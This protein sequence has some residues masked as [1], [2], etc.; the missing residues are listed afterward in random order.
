MAAQPRKASD[1]EIFAAAR[2]AMLRL[3]P[4][5]LTLKAIGEEAG[6][7]PGALVQRFGSKRELLLALARDQFGHAREL[8]KLSK[9]GASAV[10]ALQACVTSLSFLASS[11]QALRRSL[12]Y[13]QDDISDVEMRRIL[14]AAGAANRGL[15]TRLLEAALEAGELAG[16]FEPEKLA[17]LIEAAMSGAMISAAFYEPPS[18]EGWLRD[19]L[20]E[21]L[22]P[23]RPANPDA[24]PEARIARPSTLDMRAASRQRRRRI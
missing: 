14:A 18:T 12:A 10:G 9:A 7:T 15:V 5:Q 22:R 23:Y 4:R 1:E 3:D 19:L 13:L 24:P 17:V 20:D 11:P 2:R 6:L 8:P 16:D 21:L